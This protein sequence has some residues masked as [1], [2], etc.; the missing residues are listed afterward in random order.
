ML[1]EGQA[2]KLLTS[3]RPL[4]ALRWLQS[5]TQWHPYSSVW[6]SRP[7]IAWHC[8]SLTTSLQTHWSSVCSENM[9]CFYGLRNFALVLLL[10]GISFS[11]HCLGSNS[12]FS[13]QYNVTSKSF[14]W[15]PSLKQ[16]PNHTSS[17]RLIFP[18]LTAIC[19][20]LFIII[21]PMTAGPRSDH[22]IPIN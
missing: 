7:C 19:N 21:S 8:L 9:P 17:D 3:L 18:A 20:H 11:A 16:H 1:A 6:P 12:F 10:L 15:P 13:S 22:C 5:R 14:S 2:A 4:K